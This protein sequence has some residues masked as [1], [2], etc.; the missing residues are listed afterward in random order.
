[1]VGCAAWYYVVEPVEIK[2]LAY[3]RGLADRS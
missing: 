2:G 3:S 1:M